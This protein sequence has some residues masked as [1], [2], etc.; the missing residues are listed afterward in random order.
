MELSNEY[1][2]ELRRWD[3][4]LPKGSGYI[5]AA[6]FMKAIE[7]GDITFDDSGYFIEEIGIPLPMRNSPYMGEHP[8]EILKH[9]RNMDYIVE[10]VPYGQRETLPN[11]DAEDIDSDILTVEDE[12]NSMSITDES[13]NLK[14]TPTN[15]AILVLVGYFIFVKK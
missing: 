8:K 2:T 1:I 15:L 7:L 11:I 10:S 14:L 13:F 12:D 9:L 5:N 3:V 6:D 4:Q